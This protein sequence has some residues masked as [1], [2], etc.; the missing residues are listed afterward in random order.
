M[1]HQVAY[2]EQTFQG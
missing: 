2:L 1:L